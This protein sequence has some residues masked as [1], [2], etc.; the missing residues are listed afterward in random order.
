MADSAVDT[1]ETP[2]VVDEVAPVEAV[3][4]DVKE[5][6]EAEAVVSSENLEKNAVVS[7]EVGEQNGSK[8]TAPA[9]NGTEAENGT[10]NDVEHDESIGNGNGTT[11]LKR[12][13]E[14]APVVENKE[15]VEDIIAEKKAKLEEKEDV[16]IDG[17]TNGESE[18]VA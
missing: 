17:A 4:E 13:S 14:E 11:E 10:T 6:A 1:T 7:D 5:T 16:A 18:L 8:V 2:V 9:E 12:K 15:S 3:K